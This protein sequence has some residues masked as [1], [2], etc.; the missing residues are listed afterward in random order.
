MHLY[1]AKK[2]KEPKTHRKYSPPHSIF[3]VTVMIP[4]FFLNTAYK[5]KTERLQKQMWDSVMRNYLSW[6]AI[7]VHFKLD[8]R[9]MLMWTEKTSLR[10]DVIYL[11]S[12]FLLLVIPIL[13][14]TYIL[15]GSTR[16]SSWI[17]WQINGQI[18]SATIILNS[19]FVS[20]L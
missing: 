19:C 12:L 14:W 9:L 7:G 15:R 10:T 11:M 1:I 6:L 20:E 17:W 2:R 3:F 13:I 5:E 18:T 4:V 16:V 8:S